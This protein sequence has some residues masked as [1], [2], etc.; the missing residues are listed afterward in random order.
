[1]FAVVGIWC[2]NIYILSKPGNNVLR[3]NL[4]FHVDVVVALTGKRRR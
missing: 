4:C 3:P 1:M 2:V